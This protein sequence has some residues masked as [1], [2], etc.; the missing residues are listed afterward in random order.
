MVTRKLSIA[1]A[2]LCAIAPSLEALADTDA[3]EMRS[4]S[5][6]LG[7][8]EIDARDYAGA[9]ATAARAR[10]FIDVTSGL[11][12]ATNL[13]VAY[14][15]TGEYTEA[16]DACADALKLARRADEM[17]ST[18]LPSTTATALALS[19]RGVLRAVTGDTVGAAS[20]FKSAARLARDS[21]APSRNLAHL[22][23]LPAN[24]LALASEEAD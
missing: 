2:L 1:A 7:G 3:F 22:E 4:Y 16:H 21:S 24:R 18:R 14:T 20:D 13:C 9:I 23:S 19:N 17:P 5:N 10:A 8:P 12:A 11:G 15:V 6:W